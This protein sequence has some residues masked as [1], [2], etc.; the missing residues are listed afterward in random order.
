VCSHLNKL[1]RILTGRWDEEILKVN[2]KMETPDRIVFK[3]S[4]KQFCQHAIEQRIAAAKGLIQ[5]AQEAANSEEKSSAGDKY[6]TGRAMGHLQKDMHSRQLAEYVKELADL[7]SVNT[8]VIYQR[9]HAGALVETSGGSFVIAAGL[10]RQ[11]V[12]GKTIF[13]LSPRAPLAG[14]LHNKKIGESFDFNKSSLVITDLY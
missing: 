3:N 10:G 14:I 9:V 5:N 4:L 12:E 11:V 6:E 8:A 13:F 2:I 1:F 7:A